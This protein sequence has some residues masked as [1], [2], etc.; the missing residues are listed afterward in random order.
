[1]YIAAIHDYLGFG[2][3]VLL[4][5]GYFLG[6]VPDKFLLSLRKDMGPPGP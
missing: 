2:A 3:N 4:K 5:L 1:M 6:G